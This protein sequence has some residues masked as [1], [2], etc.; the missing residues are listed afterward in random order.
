MLYEFLNAFIQNIRVQHVVQVIIDNASSSNY[1][2]TDKMLMEKH[3]TFIWT[4]SAAHYINLIV[5]DMGEIYFIK[6]D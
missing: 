6:D 4:S 3:P 2:D 1:V 5:E